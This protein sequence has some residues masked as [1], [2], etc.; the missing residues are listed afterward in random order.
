VAD[1]EKF[2]EELRRAAEEKEMEKT[3]AHLLN[4]E[5]F[6]GGEFLQEEPFS[7]W[8]MEAREKYKREYLQLLKR[9]ASWHESQ[10]NYVQAIE[11]NNKYLEVDGY[12]EDICRSLMALYWETGDTLSM[13]RV[14]KRCREN[15]SRELNCGLSDETERLF[16]KL[17]AGR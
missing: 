5:S 14:F 4:A 12:A 3:V 10:G 8:C 7:E 17:L 16:R 13:G 1:I 15:L 11:Y 9:I 2:T 6:Y